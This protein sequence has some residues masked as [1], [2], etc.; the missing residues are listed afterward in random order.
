MDGKSARGAQAEGAVGYLNATT[1]PGMSVT[2]VAKD[3]SVA[4]SRRR[5][6]LLLAFLCGSGLVSGGW[7]W[8]LDRRYKSAM[9]EIES[10]I[11]AG[12]YAIAC[13][14][15]DKLLS[16]KA[17]PKGGIVYLLGSCE[18]A[19]GRN[20][21]AGEAWARVVPG[22]AFSE[23]AIRGRMRL[24]HDSGQLAAAE[25]L[26]NDAALDPRN[27]RTALLVLL[28]PTFSDLGRIDEAERLIEDRWEHLNAKGEGALEPAIKLVRQHIE[29]TLK[30]RPIETIRGF[31]DQAGRQA[32]DDD[33]VWLGRANLAIRTSAYDE[34]ERS[35]DACL[36]RRPADVPVWRARLS[37]GIATNRID[38]V[39][40]AVMHLPAA[41]AIP[42]QVHRLNAWLAAKRGD[43]AT[44]RRELERLFAVEPADLTAL[45][46]LAQ[47]AEKERQPARADELSRV[48]AEIDRLRAR[49]ERL[50]ERKQP[51]R[52]AVEMAR[53]AEQLGRRFEAR[54]F[55]TVSIS[56]D[57]DRDDL[58]HD[59]RRLSQSLA[60]VAESGQTLAELLAH[61]PGNDGKIDVTPSR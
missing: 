34:A 29:L 44:E 27:D 45:D 12:R 31:L 42:A 58:R 36:L 56:A 38:V 15:L 14:N 46:R 32:P 3:A 43:F 35:L 49:Y 47:L 1:G 61:E 50:Y 2:N 13:R 4:K 52:D 60:T 28:V 8:W 19:R 37:L 57:P 20:Q 9:E 40:Q 6:S 30:A 5:W 23:K 41:E 33:R 55:L 48:K 54:V 24:F 26:I 18:L 25:Q 21:A 22:S 17:D 39:R 16:W 51:I 7:V 11:K 10:D 59:V 53:L